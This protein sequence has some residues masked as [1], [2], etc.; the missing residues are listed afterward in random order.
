M[1]PIN[2]RLAIRQD[3]GSLLEM[4]PYSKCKCDLPCHGEDVLVAESEGIILGATSVGSK[5]ISFVYGEWKGDFEQ[6]LANLSKEV[7]KAWI[8]KLYVFPE[9]RN[10]GIGTKLVEEALKRIEER[11]LT[12]VYAG[13]HIKNEF[14][15][16]SAY[17]FEKNADATI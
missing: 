2:V 3:I 6:C 9:Y 14:K 17:I 8:S 13:I 4:P 12:E 15:D 16:I 5:D 7:S 10:Q 11:N 1:S